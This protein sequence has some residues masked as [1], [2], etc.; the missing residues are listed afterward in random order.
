LGTGGEETDRQT[1]SQ[2]EC[3]KETE[4]KEGRKE[5]RKEVWIGSG[6]R[7]GGRGM[8]LREKGRDEINNELAPSEIRRRV[9]GGIR[10]WV[11]EEGG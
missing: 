1:E 11:F 8:R 3:E 2:R 9:G 7:E 10:E 5:G 6:G 4:G